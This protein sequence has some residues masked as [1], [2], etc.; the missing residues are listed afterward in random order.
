MVDRNQISFQKEKFEHIYNRYFSFFFEIACQFLSNNEDAKEV[1]QDAFIKLWE[2]EIY[3]KPEQELKNFL[4]ILIRNKCLNHLR[5][6]KKSLKMVDSRGYMLA[7]INYKLL[8][9]T[10][11]DILLHH[12]LIG[13]IQTAISNLSPQCQEVFRL[14][15]FEDLSNK[16]IAERMD[17]SIK[18]VEANMTRAL[19]NLRQEL[20]PY[21]SEKETAG[22]S[23]LYSVLASLL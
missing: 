13:K 3:F 14:S 21:L 8:S 22:M 1:V 6:Q 11:E 9:E 15:R 7:T 2:K 17:I 20:L 23:R 19:K 18:A 5:D 16:K 4:F 10:G 12:E